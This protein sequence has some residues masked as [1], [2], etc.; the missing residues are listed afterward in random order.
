MR[1]LL[2][3]IVAFAVASV[4]CGGDSKPA[5][6]AAGGTVTDPG[7]SSPGFGGLFPSGDDGTDPADP[8]DPTD[9]PTGSDPTGDD[10]A[11]DPTDPVTDPTTDDPTTTPPADAPITG[12]ACSTHD[13]CQS[14]LCAAGGNGMEC[15]VLCN[16]GL[17]PDGYT[18]ELV[19]DLGT[20]GAKMV[21][22][23]AYATLCQPCL[24]SA[25]C[26][27]TT[28][29]TYHRCVEGDAG[30]SYCGSNCGPKGAACP[31]GY[32]CDEQVLPTGEMSRQCVAYGDMTC[33]CNALAIQTQMQTTC[34]LEGEHGVCLGLRT[35]GNAGLG[36]CKGQPPSPEVCNGLDDD[37]NGLI[38]DGVESPCG[39]CATDCTL[40]VTP[41]TSP[42][43]SPT[44]EGGAGLLEVETTTLELNFIWIAN[45]G[46]NTVS[47]LD[48]NTGRE[49]GRYYV[50]QN[51]SR[52]AVDKDGDCW[53]GCRNDGLVGKISTFEAG[54][55]DK[56]G[57][58]TIET[59][60]DANDDGVISPNEMTGQGADECVKFITKPFASE[61]TIRALGVDADNFAW[62]GGWNHAKLWRL[63]PDNGAVVQEITIP[64]NP[65]GLAID[66]QGII[67]VAGR[68]GRKLVRVDPANGSVQPLE[69]GNS[70][71][72]PYGI[73]VDAN[74]AVWI[75]NNGCGGMVAWRY[76]P[77]NGQ[78]SSMAT[79][80]NPRGV[81]ASTDGHVYVANDGASKIAKLKADTMEVVGYADLGG[82]RNPVG[83][84]VDSKGFIWAVNQ[85]S[86]SVTKIHPETLQIVGEYPVG[87]SPYTYSDMTGYALL[88]FTA[89]TAEFKHT[90]TGWNEG[91]TLWQH[92]TVTAQIPGTDSNIKVYYRTAGT[93]VELANADWSGPYGP[94]PP[95]VM[96]LQVNA[97]AKYFE[98]RVTAHAEAAEAI[99]LVTGLHVKASQQP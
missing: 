8:G 81:A 83:I 87:S 4:A 26:N 64:N 73:G 91:E 19:G 98:V 56:N 23:D 82:G 65:Y 16:E 10:P 88:N 48:T 77:E 96:P 36:Q 70:C 30:A 93:L 99:P 12:L 72:E 37:C 78:W 20:E 29:T 11:G 31:D 92:V 38:D 46:E 85:S 13:E 7:T 94:F 27:P 14:G 62:V 15:A 69:P 74:G 50:C 59:S 97:T 60:F 57:N 24:T 49:L 28:P 71:I 75:G 22:L 55:I 25:D 1:L 76:Q 80:N 67:W 51:P 5:D 53:V 39:G 79:A 41:G 44:D 2:P 52:T 84:A 42:I 58:G 40:E 9:D 17:C 35:C 54:C 66:Q 45:S 90:F 6:P 34:D 95:E 86:S 89:I 68:G 3:I 63:H 21:C 32:T 18:C 47:K 33:S 61:N 43:L